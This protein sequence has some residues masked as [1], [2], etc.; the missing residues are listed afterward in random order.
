MLGILIFFHSWKYQ[1][2]VTVFF[3]FNVV[4]MFYIEKKQQGIPKMLKSG[5]DWF[6]VNFI[7]WILLQK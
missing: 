7:S 2:L 5:V 3:M 6:I 4:Q 1:Y